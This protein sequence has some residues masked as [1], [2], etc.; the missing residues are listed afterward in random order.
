MESTS[1]FGLLL[2]RTF[3]VSGTDDPIERYYASMFASYF[4]WLDSQPSCTAVKAIA[5][6]KRSVPP[7]SLRFYWDA[8]HP[9]CPKILTEDLAALL[10]CCFYS[11]AQRT[12]LRTS[13]EAFLK[14]LPAE[15]AADILA[16]AGD[17]AQLWASLTWY[18]LCADQ[19]E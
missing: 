15:D 5:R 3:A 14:E 13:L 2:S 8:S 9:R 12:A 17:L 7:K 6:G 11:V 1:L 18:A 19:Y 10:A 4:D 16:D